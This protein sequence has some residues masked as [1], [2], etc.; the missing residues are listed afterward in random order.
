[1]D[2]IV[3]ELSRHAAIEEQVF[4]PVVRATMPDAEDMTLE[5]LEEHHVVKWLLSELD[6]M[7]PTDERFTAKTTV[8]IEN[9]R[10][11]VEEEEDDLFPK[12]RD[13]FGRRALQDLGAALQDA[14]AGAPT[15]PHPRSPDSPP[16]NVVMGAIAGA[17]DKVG[18]TVSGLTQGGV[19]AVQD[20]IDQVTNTKKAWPAPRGSSAAR[21]RAT[22]TRKA[23]AAATSGAKRTAK[24]AASGAKRTAA[25]ARTGAKRT[26]TTAKRAAR[27]TASAGRQG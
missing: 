23:S 13:E 10:H 24:T 22:T 11:H 5:S 26:A 14:K 21:S 8:L 17:I 27:E 20:L 2:R 15:H 4:Y 7:D 9:V 3:E 6:R 25:T 1:M 19:A 12:V 18:D 16:G